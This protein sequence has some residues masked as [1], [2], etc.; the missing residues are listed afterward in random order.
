MQ[1]PRLAGL[2]YAMIFSETVCRSEMRAQGFTLVELMVA[3]VIISVM[4]SIAVPQYQ[5]YI[6]RS[7]VAAG[8]AEISPGKTRYEII[9]NDGS[10]SALN[11]AA[12]IGLTVASANRC[13]AVNVHTPNA[14]G[15][16]EDAIECTIRG[17]PLVNGSKVTWARNA[18][19]TW[20]CS[21]NLTTAD[22]ERFSPSSCP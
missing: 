17:N 11:S 14:D 9:L 5:I 13:S 22:K 10:G 19:G 6:A 21:T 4:A 20:S 16:Q 7:Q 2:L 18:D 8:L 12:A 1:K 15:S 3:V